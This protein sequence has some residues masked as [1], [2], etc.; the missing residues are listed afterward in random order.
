[1]RKQD[2]CVYCGEAV[3]KMTVELR[4]EV[5]GVAIHPYCLNRYRFDV[6]RIRKAREMR[7]VEEAAAG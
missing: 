7:M 4:A 2:G 6:K 5:G 1:M 3:E